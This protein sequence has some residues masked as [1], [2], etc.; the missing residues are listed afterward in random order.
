MIFT[1]RP[2]EEVERE[3]TAWKPWFAWCPKRMSPTEVVWLAWIECRATGRYTEHWDYDSG[4]TFSE[5]YEYR[6]V[7]AK[8]KA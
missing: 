6:M 1:N 7:P 4:T 2:P 8:E 3:R 5:I